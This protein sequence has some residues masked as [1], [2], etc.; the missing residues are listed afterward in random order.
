[1]KQSL[2]RGP[3]FSFAWISIIS[4]SVAIG[5]NNIVTADVDVPPPCPKMEIPCDAPPTTGDPGADQPCACGDGSWVT[6]TTHVAC[7]PA[8]PTTDNGHIARGA[9]V[10]D[11]AAVAEA[12]PSR[13]SCQLTLDAASNWWVPI[14]GTGGSRATFSSGWKRVWGGSLPACPELRLIAC[15]GTGAAAVAV[16]ADARI[17]CSASA[18]AS[19]MGA[20]SG[21]G[22]ANAELSKSI[23]ASAQF[24]RITSRADFKGN[25]GG[26][27]RDLTPSAV[28]EFSGEDS[29]SVE[30]GGGSTGTLAIVVH[31][32][33]TYCAISNLPA[34]VGWHGSLA[35]SGAIGAGGNGTATAYS[36]ATL[37]L[38]V[39]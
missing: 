5:V 19:I 20:A 13:A 18:S 14:S 2:A 37:T 12:G 38:T 11:R 36:A 39:N 17:G 34:R 22:D 10:F 3:S 4:S 24:D 21:P 9:S 6:E 31:P 27:V 15:S 8:I 1:M 33:R 23:N 32:G 30:G 28:V 29:W 7:E 16:S 35:V 25:I 26:T